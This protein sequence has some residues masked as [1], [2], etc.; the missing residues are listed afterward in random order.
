MTIGGVSIILILGIC[1]LLLILFQLLSGL[2]VIKVKFG[3]HKKTGVTL[4][5]VAIIHG[6]LAFFAS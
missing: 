6:F 5:V 4:L 2:R 3:V 1:N